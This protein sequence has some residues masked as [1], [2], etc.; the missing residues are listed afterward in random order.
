[1]ARALGL[2]L[3]LGCCAAVTAAQGAQDPMEVCYQQ[4][5]TAARLACFDHEMQ[6]RHA[7][8][9]VQATPPAAPAAATP[10]TV[11]PTAAPRTAA[12]AKRPADDNVGLEGVALT[13]KLKEEGV[14]PEPV[15]PI[16]ATVNRLLPRPDNEYAF[17][18]DNGQTWEQA[19]A[20]AD[21]YVDRHDSVTIKPGLLGSFYM[22]TS[23]SQ[24]VRVRR[25]R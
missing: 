10:T 11:T 4:S 9:A 13:R 15:K 16:V 17:E 1:M 3:T 7:G 19:E 20:K 25:I 22:T 12:A 14:Q 2:L 5:D 24:R 21:L 23:R 8:A 6:R 18:L